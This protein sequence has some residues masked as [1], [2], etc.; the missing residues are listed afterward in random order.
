M[1]GPTGFWTKAPNR[2]AAKFDR[3]LALECAGVR[4]WRRTP[5]RE[6]GKISPS[7]N[8]GQ[9]SYSKEEKMV[10]KYNYLSV[11]PPL[12]PPPIPQLLPHL[13]L[14]VETRVEQK[15]IPICLSYF[16]NSDLAQLFKNN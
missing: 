14:S 2:Y 7:G 4:A 8:L 16:N 1:I 10:L 9:A 15:D 13:E 6:R 12:K 3:F 5:R 11:W